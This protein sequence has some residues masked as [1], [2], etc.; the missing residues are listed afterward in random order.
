MPE[1][2]S[3]EIQELRLLMGSPRDPD[4]RVFAQLGNALRK[5]GELDEAEEVLR[6]G[7]EHHPHF[8]PGHLTLG[9]VALESG[10]LEEA[11]T[12]FQRTLDLDPQ[13]PF[14]LLGLGRILEVFGDESGV[15][16]VEQALELHPTAEALTPAV[17][18][19]QRRLY[20]LP[21]L[22]LADLAPPE[23]V[24]D[25]DE[26]RDLPFTPLSGL[27][28][29]PVPGED[30]SSL[31]FMSLWDLR[32]EPEVPALDL[33]LELAAGA[34]EPDEVE[35]EEASED[36]RAEE[37]EED[38]PDVTDEGQ[39]EDAEGADATPVTRTMAE[40]LMR[41]GLLERATEVYRQLLERTPG[42]PDL[43]QRLNELQALQGS[44]GAEP[45]RGDHTLAAPPSSPALPGHPQ[46][47]S[48]DSEEVHPS[49]AMPEPDPDTPSPYAWD[50][51]GDDS[52]ESPP[53]ESSAGAY[54]G[55]LL[56]WTSGNPAPEGDRGDGVDDS[57][58][59]AVEDS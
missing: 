18:E 6:E 47:D 17:P 54:F 53:P 7:L 49:I 3:R 12:R 30:L 22:S 32:P 21:F 10:D 19:A 37:R 33:E 20:G 36:M 48:H 50:E 4:G 42:D 8:T 31:P 55:R 34:L 26:L 46:P 41:Q 28:P 38:E 43:V 16:L 52:V 51:E 40:L 27:A 56:A 15:A 29:D 9:W 23:P 39:D 35:V 24:M 5:A 59:S 14:G 13:N 58:G 1:A 11:R 44:V 57:N 25:E 45:D 2:L